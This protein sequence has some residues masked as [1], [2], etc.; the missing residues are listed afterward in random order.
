MN[1][2]HLYR[3]CFKPQSHT[4]ELGAGLS[5]LNNL[6]EISIGS[7]RKSRCLRFANMDLLSLSF[8]IALCSLKLPFVTHF[9]ENVS[10]R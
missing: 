6:V 10:P 5:E 7:L 9:V 8:R 3:R 4:S 1:N 2:N